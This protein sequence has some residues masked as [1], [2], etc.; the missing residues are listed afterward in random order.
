MIRTLL[1]V[2]VVGAGVPAAALAADAPPP[3]SATPAAA[4]SPGPARTQAQIAQDRV[5]APHLAAKGR[6][7]VSPFGYMKQANDDP[8]G[9]SRIQDQARQLRPQL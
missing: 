2:A 4:A 8:Q 9:L 1:I 6:H 7:A 3:V 5:A